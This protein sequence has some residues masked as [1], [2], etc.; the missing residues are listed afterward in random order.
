M[1]N[2]ETNQ[3][4]RRV[5]AAV[6]VTVII[7]SLMAGGTLA[8]GQQKFKEVKATPQ[9]LYDGDY[10]KN[11]IYRTTYTLYWNMMHSQYTAEMQ[12]YDSEAQL[13]YPGVRDMVSFTGSDLDETDTPDEDE[14]DDNGYESSMPSTGKNS[15]DK[16]NDTGSVGI[17]TD[18]DWDALA[19]GVEEWINNYNYM[20]NWRY[21]DIAVTDTKT[22]YAYREGSPQMRALAKGEAPQ[23]VQ[24]LT[25]KYS[26]YI[27][28][29]YDEKGNIS[30]PF[31]YGA[32]WKIEDVAMEYDIEEDFGRYLARGRARGI[33]KNSFQPP[34]NVR[35]VFGIEKAY[36]MSQSIFNTL[37]WTE[38]FNLAD[39]GYA[40]FYIGMLVLAALLGIIL[41][42]VKPLNL[43]GLGLA[44]MPFE[45]SI[46]FGGL[47]ACTAE[48]YVFSQF[49]TGV[50]SGTLLS[51]FV[52]MGLAPNA[53]Y[54]AG[55]ILLF[56][57]CFAAFGAMYFAAASLWQIRLLGIKNYL[58]QKSIIVRIIIWVKNRIAQFFRWATSI[59]L[60]KKSDKAI[61]KILFANLV[62]VA[63]LC[64]FWFGGII[65]AIIYTAVLLV[66]L[67]K[68]AAK[69]RADYEKVLDATRQMA[70]GR[71]DVPMDE[72]FGVFEPM[73]AEL[74]QIQNGFQK[75]VIA[76]TKSQNMKTEL[77]T[78]VSHD[79]KTPLTAIITYVGLLQNEDITDEERAEYIGTLDAKS[80]KLKRLIEDL[81][82]VSKA[83]SNDIVLDKKTVD[84]P[85][86]VRQVVAENT[87]ELEKAKLE[88]RIRFAEEKQELTLDGEKTSR[89]FENLV[90]NAAKYSMENTRVYIEGAAADGEMIVEVKNV[91]R[92]ELA[93]NKDDLT[94]RFVRGD[95]SRSTEGSG[96]GLAIAK[97]FT[98]VQGGSFTV[99][100]DGDMFKA[101]V[102]F[103]L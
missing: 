89:I 48:L 74:A 60:S 31:I 38:V 58:M 84:L 43:N 4:K 77:I 91:S 45:F 99:E 28:V 27:V 24:D 56:A 8:F 75:A 46:L 87:D 93:F 13:F 14:Y 7:L 2:T 79:L 36:E 51:E 18:D 85:A 3:P 55:N 12:G 37:R 69:T 67:Q 66:F 40:L 59:D 86:L 17:I 78:N 42:M 70:E 39:S 65:L 44:R 83:S 16:V 1:Q 92:E 68:R 30:T 33:I 102:S 29:E 88:V 101:R 11:S 62:V 15:G 98:E 41:A 34:Q 10:I 72:D 49:S 9:D 71:L 94:E 52:R 6:L 21:D 47:A 64:C 90:L 61:A 95:A 5:W 35:F 23:N 20:N 100:T 57:A 80:Q 50:Y 32:D 19:Q 54:A 73:K 25:E 63:V 22:G 81:F 53:A 96:L 26:F 97:S 82:E 103:P 76:E